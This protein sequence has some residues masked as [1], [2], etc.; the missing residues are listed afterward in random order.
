MKD[1]PFFSH[2]LTEFT[3]GWIVGRFTPALLQRDDIEV[4]IKK[5]AANDSEPE[6]FH[7]L[8]DEYTIII[9]GEVQ[10]N[11][12]VFS[13]GEIVCI[14]AGV[15]CTFMALKDSTTLVLRSGSSPEDKRLSNAPLYT[16]GR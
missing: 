2:K 15:S 5:Y 10:M 14:P 9:T 12:V 8:S 3:R 6:H 13:E 7:M 11:G 4:G 1:K 16:N